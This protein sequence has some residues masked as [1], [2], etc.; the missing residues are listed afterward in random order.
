M[1]LTLDP[2]SFFDY[3][4]ANGWRIGGNPMRDWQAALRRWDK[5]GK[6]NTDA[7]VFP[8]VIGTHL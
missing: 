2:D 1:R 8:W 7:E 6:E 4:S 3:Y 5:N